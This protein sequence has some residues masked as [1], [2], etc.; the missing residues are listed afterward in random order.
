MKKEILKL[1]FLLN[2]TLN[3]AITSVEGAQEAIS[4]LEAGYRSMLDNLS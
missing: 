4:G 1:G 3:M 2:M